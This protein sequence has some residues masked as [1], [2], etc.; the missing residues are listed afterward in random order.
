[1]RIEAPPTLHSWAKIFCADPKP[2][3]S[4]MF[5]LATLP[6]MILVMAR[7][8]PCSIRNM[9]SVTRKLGRPVRM[10]M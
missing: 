2:C 8:R 7:L 6:V 9:A 10:T 1:M 3:M 5:G 4:E